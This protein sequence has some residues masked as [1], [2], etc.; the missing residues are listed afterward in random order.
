MALV[1]G[2][3]SSLMPTAKR[4]RLEELISESCARDGVEIH[5]G[6]KEY[7]KA[8]YAASAECGCSGDWVC[9]FEQVASAFKKELPTD[10]KILHLG[11][12]DSEFAKDMHAAGYADTL[13]T[14]VDEGVI[15]QQRLRSP[16]LQ[17]GVLDATEMSGHESSSYDCVVE[18]GCL[19]IFLP[20]LLGAC[21]SEEEEEGMLTN[22]GKMLT[23]VVITDSSSPP[24]LVI[25]NQAP[26]SSRPRQVKLAVWGCF[27]RIACGNSR[28]CS[29]QG[30]SLSASR[31]TY[32]ARW[33]VI[34]PDFPAV[35]VCLLELFFHL[36]RPLDRCCEGAAEWR[37]TL[38]ASG[39]TVSRSHTR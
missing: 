16:G 24:L 37:R 5:H 19:D 27:E 36:A 23:E 17:W 7:W 15:Q 34:S 14:D 31:C 35:S 8:R 32:T 10:A 4:Q 39:Q 33:S 9:G 3:P 30:G 20:L 2:D 21:T 13:H 26:D 22:A 28:G 12:G 25:F 11:C 1:H 38:F 29:S 6:N 18:K